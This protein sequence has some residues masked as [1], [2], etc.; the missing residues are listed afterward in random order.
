MP[1]EYDSVSMLF[2]HHRKV[3]LWRLWRHPVHIISSIF[4]S[5]TI[6]LWRRPEFEKEGW[7]EHMKPTLRSKDPRARD[8]IVG[9]RRSRKVENARGEVVTA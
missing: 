8:E 9:G 4:A 7:K 5:I 6:I 1:A 3:Y 2:S